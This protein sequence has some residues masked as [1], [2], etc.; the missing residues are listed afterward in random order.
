MIT[1]LERRLTKLE[2]RAP[3]SPQPVDL[4]V[5]AGALPTLNEQ[6]RIDAANALDHFVMVVHLVSAS[7][8][9]LMAR[10]EA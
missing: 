9:R 5:L 3:G 10:C 1:T 8:E 2:T 6:E 7:H 4:I